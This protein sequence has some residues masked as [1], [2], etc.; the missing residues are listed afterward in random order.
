MS[1]IIVAI[2]TEK[3]VFDKVNYMALFFKFKASLCSLRINY[4]GFL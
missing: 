1:I 4:L 3:Q 2:F